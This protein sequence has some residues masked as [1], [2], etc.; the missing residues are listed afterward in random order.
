MIGLIGSL[1]LTDVPSLKS[2]A[3]ISNLLMFRGSKILI[4]HIQKNKPPSHEPI[5]SHNCK[6]LPVD[7][8]S[9]SIKLKPVVVKALTI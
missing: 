5:N 4:A 3:P 8:L 7:D 6:A 1:P 9:R 2:A